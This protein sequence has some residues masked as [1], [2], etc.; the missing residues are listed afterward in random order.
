MSSRRSDATFQTSGVPCRRSNVASAPDARLENASGLPSTMTG[1]DPAAISRRSRG[2]ERDRVSGCR[3]STSFVRTRPT[4]GRLMTSVRVLVGQRPDASR[5]GAGGAP[6]S[7][8]TWPGYLA[9]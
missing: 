7:L 9:P 2:D 5:S 4:P 8:A 3:V 6:G 1:I